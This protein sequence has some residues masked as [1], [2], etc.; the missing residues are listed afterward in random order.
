MTCG[1]A[2]RYR[3][4]GVRMFVSACLIVPWRIEAWERVGRCVLIGDFHD[5]CSSK[6]F[7]MVVERIWPLVCCPF[8]PACDYHETIAPRVLLQTCVEA[9]PELYWNR[10][11]CCWSKSPPQDVR[12]ISW[13]LCVRHLY[14]PAFLFCSKHCSSRPAWARN[15]S[16]VP[17]EAFCA[18]DPRLRVQ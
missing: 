18:W 12:R 3:L 10:S 16:S 8:R 5:G 13:G 9:C 11:S 7:R 15:V 2:T 14:L 17:L 6:M 1:I 4:A